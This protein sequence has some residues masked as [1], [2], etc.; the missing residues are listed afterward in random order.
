MTPQELTQAMAAIEARRDADQ[1][2]VAETIPLG[3][4]VQQLGLEMTPEELL[5]EINAQRTAAQTPPQL[6][7]R[8]QTRSLRSRLKTAVIAVSLA[9]NLILGFTVLARYEHQN[10]APPAPPPAAQPLAANVAGDLNLSNIAPD[11]TFYATHDAL[12][13]MS[14]GDKW[15]EI[16]IAQAQDLTRNGSAQWAIVKRA[17]D[18]VEV[19]GWSRGDVESGSLSD[20]TPVK[21]D[22]AQHPVTIPVERFLH[23]KPPSS[24]AANPDTPGGAG[25][26]EQ[27]SVP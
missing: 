24:F 6:A 7:A 17:G 2:H 21:S 5:A 14:H 3:E 23:V 25:T 16:P 4:A 10:A 9:A 8:T 18:K 26:V 11:T 15:L 12:Y 22:D 1:M 13:Q 20:L 27:L 19:R